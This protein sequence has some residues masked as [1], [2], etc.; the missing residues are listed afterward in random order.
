MNSKERYARQTILPEVGEA[1]QE[2]LARARV[3]VVGAGALGTP[4]LYYLAAAGVGSIGIADDD[5]LELSNLHR[6]ILYRS[7]DIGRS[8]ADAATER[9]VEFNPD[10]HAEAHRLRVTADNA[11]ALFRG[12]DIV[13]DATDRLATK[14]LI[15]DA[16]AKAERPL[17]HA[18]ILGFEARVAVFDARRGPCLRCLF[19]APPD[20]P[21]LTCAEAGVI[22]AVPGMAGSLQALEAIKWVLAAGARTAA[23]QGLLGRLWLMDGRR[24]ET[25][26][27]ELPR[28]PVCPIC[29]HDPVDIALPREA[30]PVRQVAPDELD[31]YGDALLLDVR[32]E[33]EWNAGH[34]EGAVH[35][36]LSH[37]MEGAPQLPERERYIAYCAHGIRSETAA[38]LLGEAGYRNV[39]SLAGGIAAVRG[40]AGKPA[41]TPE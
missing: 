23:L 31:H 8:K 15:N 19:P 22:G 30:P 27:V 29:R 36:P 37:L 28:D 14:F 26:V 16:C 13:L 7:G 25:R 20:T 21:T 41:R 3:L 11:V 9:L 4:A 38:R 2:R 12:Y 34:L 24:L 18:A 39:F 6:Q 32:E 1:G 40:D 35:C 10:I 33:E 5:V 17:V